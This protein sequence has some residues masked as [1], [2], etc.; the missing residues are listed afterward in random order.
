MNK[1]GVSEVVSYV[2]LIIIAMAIAG[3]VYG[4]LMVYVPKEK[5]ECKEGIDIIVNDVECTEN[6]LLKIV[7]EN[8]GLFEITKAYI[9]IGKPGSSFKEDI[10]GSPANILN[11]SGGLGIKPGQLSNFPT[12]S[13]PASY[14]DPGNY[15]LEVQPAYTTKQGRKNVDSLCPAITTPITCTGS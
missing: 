9:R 8:R 4:F 12:F 15:I 6:G 3:I 1:R 14:D 10:P 13:R 5:P 2:L 7:L 11:E